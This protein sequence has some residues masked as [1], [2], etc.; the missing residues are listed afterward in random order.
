MLTTP[1]SVR[2]LSVTHLIAFV[3][4]LVSFAPGGIAQTSRTAAETIEPWFSRE[5]WSPGVWRIDDHGF[6]NVYVVV[7]SE[8]ALV[9]DTGMGIADLR[10]EVREITDLP[11]VVLNTHAHPDHAGGN[12]QF[13]AVKAAAT[14][15]DLFA[16]FTS[17]PLVAGNIDRARQQHPDMAAHFADL[18][19]F[20]APTLV[21]VK[22]GDVIDLG[23]RRL[24]ILTMPGHTPGSLSVLDREN[25]ILF[26]GDNCNTLVWLF[27]DH[28]LPLEVFQHSLQRQFDRV[29]EYDVLYPGHGGPNPPAL[30]A[31]QIACIQG[32]LDG[33]LESEPYT[34]FAGEGRVARFGTAQVTFNPDKLR[35]D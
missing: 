24:E 11:L 14:E 18:E 1:A 15:A 29:D 12:H 35:A 5:E 13:G 32:V 8:K 33:E 27:L 31:D 4:G 34:S 2:R 20:A 10:A 28:S 7:G 3:L 23:D 19:T 30:M 9:I 17:K 16:L 6:D 26:T 21:P 22:D 25:R